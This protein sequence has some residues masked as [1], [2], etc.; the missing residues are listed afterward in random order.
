MMEQHCA[1]RRRESPSGKDP[2]VELQYI[3][4]LHLIFALEG[5]GLGCPLFP[6]EASP[7][8]L[9]PM[10]RNIKLLLSRNAKKVFVFGSDC[11]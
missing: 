3:V 6:V 10:T 11:Q 7:K 2:T 4:L 5:V 9:A 8:N 1:R